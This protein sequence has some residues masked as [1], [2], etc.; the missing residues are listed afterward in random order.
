[1]VK[2][3]MKGSAIKE[4]FEH[5]ASL[6]N[7]V[8]QVYKGIRLRYDENKPAG[9]RVASLQIYGTVLDV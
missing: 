7:G 1:M 3:E 5:A 4:M 8:L 2:L 9:S 6:A